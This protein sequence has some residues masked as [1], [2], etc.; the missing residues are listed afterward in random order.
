MANSSDYFGSTKDVGIFL[1]HE[2]KNRGMFLGC[3]KRTKEFFGY[4]KKKVVILPLS[5][6]LDL[7][8]KKD[9]T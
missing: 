4:A 7:S 3:A 6:D 8:T 9:H 5:T 1:G 2:K